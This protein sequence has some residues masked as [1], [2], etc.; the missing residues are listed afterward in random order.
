MYSLL[1][2]RVKEA[3]R[4]GELLRGF[5][6]LAERERVPGAHRRL[7]RAETGSAGARAEGWPT[8][9]SWTDE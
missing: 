7:A 8:R 4:A 3:K 9:Q 6:E 1:S 2:S 5:P